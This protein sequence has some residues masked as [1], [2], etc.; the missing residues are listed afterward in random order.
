MYGSGNI[1]FGSIG[2]FNNDMSNEKHSL[3]SDLFFQMMFVSTA[4]SVISGAVAERMKMIPFFI[5]IV[6]LT[7]IIYPMVGHWTWGG[8]Y[9]G[10]IIE[11]FSDFAGSTIVHSVGGWAALAGVLVLGARKG[12]YTKNGEVKPILGSNLTLATL[13]VFILWMGWFGFNGG[14]QLSMSSKT[15]IEDISNILLNTHIGACSGILGSMI[16]SYIIYKKIDLTFILNGTLAGLVAV[17]AGPNLGLGVA[18]IEG[19]VGGFLVV[20]S[21]PLFDKFKIDDPVGAL[22]VHLVVGIWGTLA[23]GLFSPTITLITQLKGIFIIGGFVFVTSYIIWKI[24]DLILKL[25]VEDKIE[26]EGLDL[27]ETGLEC[28]PEFK[29][30]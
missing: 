7:S 3:G 15:D 10:G 24:L 16:L 25:R 9:L 14:S 19:L 28:Y 6:I 13:G 20:L 8:T 26:Y 29:R 17:T 18:F 21:I 27:H 22:S 1:L 23:V 30:N 12:K 2:I 4:A 5:F 11:G